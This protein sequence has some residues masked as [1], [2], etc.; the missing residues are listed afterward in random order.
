[1]DFSVYKGRI[2]VK[3]IRKISTNNKTIKGI[4]II[5]EDIGIDVN[6][7]SYK[8]VKTKIV[9]YLEKEKIDIFV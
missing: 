7:G 4:C 5:I 1:M 2:K 9:C 8:V 6:T 3:K